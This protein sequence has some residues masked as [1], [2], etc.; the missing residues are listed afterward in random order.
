MDQ[1]R[2]DFEDRG[3]SVEPTKDRDVTAN[4]TKVQRNTLFA[5]AGASLVYAVSSV[6]TSGVEEEYN[7]KI[8]EL[9]STTATPVKN[10]KR[11]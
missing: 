10:Q 7:D 6:F 3:W 11:N 1:G 9:E 2:D 8:L 5:T 4:V